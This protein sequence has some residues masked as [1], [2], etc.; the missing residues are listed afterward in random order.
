MHVLIV[1]AHPERQSFNGAMTDAAVNSLSDA[2]HSVV[3]SDLYRESFAAAAGPGDVTERANTKVFNLG[4]EQLHASR[5]ACF[6]GDI[7]RELDRLFAAD[8]LILQFPMWWYS[9]PAILKGWIDRVFAFGSAYDFGRTWNRGVFAGKKAMLSFTTGAP[10]T[11]FEPDGRNGDME[12]VLW[13]LHAGVLALV[14]YDVLSPFIGFAP[15]WIGDG[16]RDAILQRYRDRLDGI[17]TEQPMFFHKLEDFDE[18]SRLRADVEPGTPCQHRG[19][20]V[21]LNST[22][23]R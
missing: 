3:V 4:E 8:V 18:N 21:H 15:A 2:G 16:G 10:A 11:T 6:A 20:R 17:A 19:D 13:P 1:L 5:H 12:R 7:R 14:G 9:V 22:Q 23:K